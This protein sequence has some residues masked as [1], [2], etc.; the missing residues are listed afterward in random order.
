MGR[1]PVKT[2]E[3]YGGQRCVRCALCGAPLRKDKGES[4]S[5]AHFL[6]A[7]TGIEPVLSA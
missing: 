1:D 2:K 6:A 5:L 4:T 7:P 3:A